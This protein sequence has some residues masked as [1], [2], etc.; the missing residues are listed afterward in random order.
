MTLAN[1]DPAIEGPD[2]SPAAA[3]VLRQRR[4]DA[5]R[6]V[7]Y[8][9]GFPILLLLAW[10]AATRMN[11]IDIR[12]FPSPTRIAAT[13]VN[14]LTTPVEAAKLVG[15][16]LATVQRL[17]L[18]YILGAVSG[19]VAGAAMGRYKAV[20]YAL[21]PL[22]YATFPTPKLA[23]FPLLI[24]IFGLGDT[25][26]TALVT[27]A[28]FYMTAINTM[29]G[30]I[31]ANPIYLDFAKAFRVPVLTAWWRVVLPSA[32]PSIM[33]GLKLGIGQALIM[34]VSA[35]FV[36]S[37]NGVGYYIWNSWQVLDVAR[38]F[39]GLAVVMLIGGIAVWLSNQLE[40]YLLP[41]AKR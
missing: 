31:H 3:R 27:L 22:V 16:V 19:I 15:D 14:I 29:S 26:K 38:M 25:S 40:R 37:N 17:V 13:A 9:A 21:G 1:M 18:G 8:G 10:E 30:V 12:F 35:E 5:V 4:N 34:V 7:V 32:L 28:V 2:L 36:S 39:V 6:R 24:V 11:L 23:I 20:R 33:A 41:W